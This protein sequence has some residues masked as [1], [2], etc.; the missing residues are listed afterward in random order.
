MAS[1]LQVDLLHRAH[2][3]RRRR[4]RPDRHPPPRHPPGAGGRPLQGRG[5]VAP[6]ADPRGQPPRPPA[7]GRPRA[8]GA[9]RHAGRGHPPRPGLDHRRR[10][11]RRSACPATSSSCGAP[12]PASPACASW[13]PRPHWEPPAPPEDGTLSDLDRA[14]DVLVEM[15]NISEVAVGL[16]LLGAG[17]A[18]PG[19]GRRGAPPRGPPRRD[20]GPP[21]AV[22]AAGR[23]GHRR[24]GAA[25]GPAPP[26][27]GG[28][29]PRRR[30]P[31]DGVAHRG[32][33]GAPPDP[34]DRPRATPTRSWCGCRW[35]RARRPT[36][37]PS[38]ELQLD[39]EPGFHVLAVQRGG[40]YLYRPDGLVR[41]QPGDELIASGPD[42]GHPTARG[43][44]C[45]WHLTEDE[46]T[47]EHTLEPLRARQPRPPARAR[48]SR[49]GGRRRRRGGCRW[50]RRPTRRGTWCSSAKA[51]VKWKAPCMLVEELGGEA[52]LLPGEL[53]D[54]LRPLEVRAGHAAGVGE[55][56]GDR[57][58][59]PG[60]A[61][62]LSASGVTG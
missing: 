27:P 25:A 46:D 23:R 41:L 54:V 20:E 51:W 15:K 4:H 33:G 47:G 44:R 3:Q 35:R 13:P 29:G 17:P 39:I 60:R 10:R 45:G 56:V 49:G 6:G 7:A 42:E 14:V 57:R 52:L 31:A 53:L 19:P 59:C 62:T 61:R 34:V 8:A 43:Q 16:G 48:C 28:R 1:V 22:G 9:D 5:G 2:R 55:D 36:G 11:R 32:E 40:R 12:R 58:R 30:R 37:P 26:L 24:P 21:R 50:R 38:A 18:R